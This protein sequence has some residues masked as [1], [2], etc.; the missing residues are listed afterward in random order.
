MD[1]LYSIFQSTLSPEPN[2]RVRAELDLRGV[3]GQVGM[4]PGVLQIIASEQAD[5][6][7]RQAAAM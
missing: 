7:V 1:A 2:T 5:G 6:G 4:L 3:E